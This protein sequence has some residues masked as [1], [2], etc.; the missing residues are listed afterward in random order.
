MWQQSKGNF[1][2]EM[3]V[4]MNRTRMNSCIYARVLSIMP[5][6]YM[7]FRVLS[8]WGTS[9]IVRNIC[10]QDAW[11]VSDKCPEI[12]DYFH[13]ILNPTLFDCAIPETESCMHTLYH[14]EIKHTIKQ[15]APC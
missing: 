14:R 1:D 11:R 2:F 4:D 8:L 12:A 6:A 15:Y 9:V 13:N 5:S 10:F 3:L 7:S